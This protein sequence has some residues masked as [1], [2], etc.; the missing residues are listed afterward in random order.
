MAGAGLPLA[1]AQTLPFRSFGLS[2]GLPETSVS[3]LAQDGQGRLWLVSEVGA[4]WYDGHE[5]HSLT[6]RSGLPNTRVTTLAPD[7][8]PG[9]NLWLGMRDGSICYYSSAASRARR[10]T[11]RRAQGRFNQVLT[12]LPQGEGAGRRLWVGTA[13]GALYCLRWPRASLPADSLAAPAVQ[14]VQAQ[15]GSDD[16]PLAINA[17]AAAPAGGLW[18]GSDEGLRLLDEA[19]GRPRPLP[20]G[21]PAELRTGA[22]LGLS[23][24]PDGRLWCS[25]PTAGLF[26]LDPVVAGSYRARHYTTAQGLCSDRVLRATAE[27]GPTGR[28]WVLTGKGLCYLPTA[29]A[30]L[31]RCLPGTGLVTHSY[32]RGDLLLD[33]EGNLWATS[34]NG[35]TQYLPDSRFVLFDAAD[36]LPGTKVYALAPAVGETGAYWVGTNNG[37][38]LLH[39]GTATS[40]AR[41][42]VLPRREPDTYNVVRA[43]L[44][45]ANGEVWVGTTQGGSGVWEASRK[46]W[47]L[48]SAEIPPL[49]ETT[50]A[51]MLEDRY[52][53]IWLAT[54]TNGLVVYDPAT[55]RFEQY[56]GP[57][58]AGARR[59][60]KLLRG[61][62][63]TIWLGTE[64]AG[65][66]QAEEVAPARA[67]AA[68]GL[69]FRA[70]APRAASAEPL[71]VFSI[72]EDGRGRLWLS[73]FGEGI[74]TYDPAQPADGLH[75]VPLH[76]APG[77]HINNPYFVQC[78]AAG[79]VWLG[80]TRGL[81]RY[82]PATGQQA[83]F[84]YEEG[85]IGQETGINA[86]L[87]EPNGTL[88][89]GTVAG[90]MR[91]LPTDARPNRV[92]PY[93]HLTGLRLF[94]RDTALLPGAVLP[95]QFN[96][97]TF[98][99]GAVSLTNPGRVRY[100]YRLAG[101]ENQ[102]SGP[103]AARSA[104]Y[105]NLPPGHYRFELRAANESGVWSPRPM[106]YSFSIRPPW[107][108]TWWAYLLYASGFGLLLYAVRAYTKARERDRAERQLEHQALTYLKE[109]DRVK[110]DFFTNVSHELR[111]P[112]T[113]ILGPAEVL[114]TTPADPAVRQ[115][116]SVV[117]RSARRLLTL[118]NQLLDLSKLEAG[119]LRLLPTSGDAAAEVRQLVVSFAPLAESRQITLQCEIPAEPVPLVFD[120]AKLEEMMTNLLANALRFTPAGGCVTVSVMEGPAT[121]AAPAGSVA[122]AVR[123]TGPGIAAEDLPHLFDRFYQANN[124]T[125][126]QRTGTGIGLALVRELAGLH[127]GSVAVTSAPGAGATFTVEIPRGLRPV[128]GA[129]A[130][131]NGKNAP[132][133]GLEATPTAASNPAN[134]EPSAV[135]LDCET[136]LIIEDNDEVREFIR[137]T[138][139][140]AGY[141]LL[142]ATDGLAGLATARAEVPDLVLSDVMM[143]GL[144][145]YQ[146]CQQLKTDPATSHI[147]VVLL[148]AK[149]SPDAK[150]EG[151]ETGADSFLAKPFSPRELQAQV[152]NL[153]ALRRRVQARFAA[154]LAAQANAAADRSEEAPA[155]PAPDPLA[156]HLAAV[157]GRPS[158]DQ[159]FLRRISE[160]VLRHLADE[161]F[162][163]DQLG[164]DIGMSRTQVHR[165]LKALTG[166]SPGEY[167]R[168]MR[169]H[170]ALALLRAQVGTVAEVSYQ[171]GFGSPAAFSTAFSRQFGYPPSAAVR[172]AEAA[173]TDALA[174]EGEAV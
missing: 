93:P 167:I 92:P 9:A 148:T 60:M 143:P 162:G 83:F 10:I 62:T 90:L 80:T 59:V 27:A 47:R 126:Q 74:F 172:H 84:G 146:A 119:A 31:A 44:P 37:L 6:T 141:R 86:V 28:V 32:R 114:A 26:V 130:G 17:L 105:T 166:Q 64:G 112:L 155:T 39:P 94:M 51:N 138:L 45:R 97:L 76:D 20:A 16:Q 103:L 73:S 161:T 35:L 163:V 117:L 56:V 12:L 152:R 168:S 169:L 34:A 5:F 57:T 88:W 108:R 110:T 120:A 85:F 67:G 165:K 7:P 48:L 58:L 122:M 11:P 14:Q 142:L 121:P 156:A 30:A 158:L 42:L 157:A 49:A 159:E 36:G 135:D 38:A 33:R 25:T 78:D 13:G 96:H 150:L 171:V 109:L 95:H 55:A 104:T 63:G 61:R 89:A 132:A 147:P 65:L 24:A 98:G 118:I 116:G 66:V 23:A 72:S 106:T 43:V 125:D 75:P 139:A 113:L 79:A 100:Q 8:G 69:R 131:A 144:D 68:P 15:A 18:V 170:R 123:D 19:T 133:A 174:T 46:R 50:V 29:T 151:L 54:E 77:V 99:Y 41:C 91:Y 102:W 129:G 128:A 4:A 149:S 107:W 22:V 153:L 111:T 124:P 127:G 160:A 52:G 134:T 21:L 53:R 173:N 2:Q 154:E 82:Q 140:P 81:V 87:A 137:A 1:H 115:Q 145:G 136:V 40:A 3:A 70:V 164:N 101:F 71:S